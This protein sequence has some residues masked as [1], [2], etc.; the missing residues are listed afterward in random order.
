MSQT[1]FLKTVPEIIDSSLSLSEKLE[2]TVHNT[3]N[4]FFEHAVEKQIKNYTVLN[5]IDD[6]QEDDS[7]LILSMS[8]L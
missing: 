3:G 1:Y 4:Y 5:E 7:T 2:I 8:N 6:I